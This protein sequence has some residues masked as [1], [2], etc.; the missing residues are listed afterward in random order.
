MLP[1]EAISGHRL[2]LTGSSLDAGAAC[3]ATLSDG[4]ALC[5]GVPATPVLDWEPIP[6][7]SEY[8]VHVSRDAD[9][10]T[11]QLDTTPPRTTNTRWAP[12]FTYPFKALQESQAQTPYYWFIQACKS[13]TKC[14]PGPNSTVSPARHA[15]RKTSPQ[16]QLS[17]PAPDAVI[18]ATEVTFEWEDYF[19]TNRATTY[20]ATDEQSYQSARSYQVQ[21]DDDPAFSSPLDDVTVDQTTYTSTDQLYPEGPLWWRVQPI[22]ANGN[23]LGWSGVRA[24]EKE[25]PAPNL[26]SPVVVGGEVPVVTGAVPF[27]WDALPF[28]GGYDVQVAANADRNFS[29]TNLKVNTV[30]KRS[31][32]TT[33]STVFPMVQTLQAADSSYVWRVRRVDPDRQQGSL[34]RRRRVQGPA[35]AAH[36]AGPHRRRVRGPARPGAALGRGRRGEQVPRRAPH[37]GHDVRDDHADPGHR[38]GPRRRP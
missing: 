16:L 30:A 3:T 8:R 35:E 32:F 11:G 37:P 6:Y 27:R 28:A 34:V 18:D 25:S 2:A 5:D 12:T 23:A 7:A 9:F 29:S 38:P 13:A 1:L 31:A 21:V 33:G 26:T 4:G 10:T 36:V 22:D 17:S 19:T 20:A 24:F 14:G 15:F